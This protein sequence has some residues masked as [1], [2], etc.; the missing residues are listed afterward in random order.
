MAADQTTRDNRERDEFSYEY[1][2]KV[3]GLDSFSRS[4]WPRNLRAVV[5]KRVESNIPTLCRPC[6][7]ANTGKSLTC[8]PCECLSHA[9][10]QS[11]L[12]FFRLPNKHI[13][14]T[15]YYSATVLRFNHAPALTR[16]GFILRVLATAPGST[17][18]FVPLYPPF[19]RIFLSL[20]FY[21]VLFLR[22]SASIRP[23][24]FFFQGSFCFFSSCILQ[25]RHNDDAGLLSTEKSLT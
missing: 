10:A 12:F 18:T 11:F 21:F 16:L 13:H 8:R 22:L 9:V 25:M 3:C 4:I 19:T 15:V 2:A 14:G 17:Y 1:Q 7:D 5:L 6:S 24:L 23:F 20:F